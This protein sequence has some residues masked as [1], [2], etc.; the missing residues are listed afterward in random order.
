MPGYGQIKGMVDVTGLFVVP[1]SVKDQIK[2]I[3]DS[4]L[5]SAV[6]QGGELP[7]DALPEEG[8]WFAI[9]Q[10][11]DPAAAPELY[12]QFV[13]T[14]GAD[15]L[16][17]EGTEFFQQIQSAE[18][19]AG[20]V[21]AWLKVPTVS[22]LALVQLD[23]VTLA[24]I[25]KVDGKGLF[26][27]AAVQKFK[28]FLSSNADAILTTLLPQPGEGLLFG[29]AF[30]LQTVLR[31]AFE[32]ATGNDDAYKTFTDAVFAS[33]TNLSDFSTLTHDRL[34]LPD[35]ANWLNF[36]LYVPLALTPST[37]VEVTIALDDNGALDASRTP[38]D[39][40][41]DPAVAVHYRID[42][43][44]A[45]FQNIGGHVPIPQDWKGHMVLIS[46]KEINTDSNL[47]A[48]GSFVGADSP[49]LAAA[50]S[51]NLLDA[52]SALFILQNV[53]LGA[54]PDDNQYVKATPA[55]EI[56]DA[57]AVATGLETAA[58]SLDAVTAAAAEARQYWIDSGL[59]PG[60]SSRLAT[61]RL[62]VGLLSG[63]AVGTYANDTITI[64]A[65]GNGVGWYTGLEAR[66]SPPGRMAC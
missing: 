22:P 3:V 51:S 42:I 30:A 4:Y 1:T 66:S 6:R 8:G 47:S 19:F 45:F 58:L 48:D 33:V 14:F 61:V 62:N 2:P 54:T 57:G 56:G 27:P 34:Y 55:P 26:Q 9:P 37:K 59:V 13:K 24:D 29:G 53:S 49:V 11:P 5:S 17:G 36:D 32:L 10:I 15:G 21:E 12:A 46:F 20:Q 16:G 64:D 35:S 18:R 23:G 31:T 44:G 43:D 52:F 65:T 39:Q 7:A 60:A 25:F 63:G 40:I 28:A 38:I 41:A 50:G